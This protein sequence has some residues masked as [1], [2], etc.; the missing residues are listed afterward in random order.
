MV[1]LYFS[2][3]LKRFFLIPTPFADTAT[4]NPNYVS[5]LLANVVSIILAQGK[6]FF[7]NGPR[8]PS[9]SID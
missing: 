7:I 3:I 5:T 8:N 9:D 4:I 6:P 1:F 2:A